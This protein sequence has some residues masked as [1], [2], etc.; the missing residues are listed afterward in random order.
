MTCMQQMEKSDF[1]MTELEHLPAA[2]RDNV[3]EK[4]VKLITTKLLH[5]RLI[6]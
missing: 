2:Y 3:A 6:F 1:E 5:I 4:N